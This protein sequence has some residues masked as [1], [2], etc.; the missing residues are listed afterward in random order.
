M[1]RSKDTFN[2]REKEKKRIKQREDK[3][4]KMEQRKANSDKGRSL[5]DMMA[6]IDE[7]GNITSTPPDPKKAPRV[8]N[9]EDIQ[10][11]VPKAEDISEEDSI[12]T[13]IVTFFNGAKGFGFIEDGAS[14]ER[15]FVHVNQLTEAI[16]ERDKVSYEVE[17][18]PR[19]L[20]AV[21]VR[22]A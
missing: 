1:A 7:N 15:I 2:K 19:G 13:G 9:V 17:S 18:G 5:D 12:R 11:G 10:I 4:E 20:S 14:G 3:K 8:F 6:Y 16:N 22:K 21:N